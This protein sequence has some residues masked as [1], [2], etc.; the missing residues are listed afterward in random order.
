MSSCLTA[1]STPV[2]WMVALKT[3]ESSSSPV[4]SFRPPLRAC[5]Q[6]HLLITQAVPLTG[7][8]HFL[9]YALGSA[10]KSPR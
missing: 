7:F 2:C 4:Q 9:A 3:V 10:S 8:I 5:T 1:G 6:H